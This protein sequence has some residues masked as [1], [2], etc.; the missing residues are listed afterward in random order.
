MHKQTYLFNIQHLLSQRYLDYSQLEVAVGHR[1]PTKSQRN[2]LKHLQPP[3]HNY[4]AQALFGYSLYILHHSTLF[5]G[6]SPMAIS[7]STPPKAVH[8]SNFPHFQP[9][10]FVFSLQMFVA[11]ASTALKSFSF[12]FLANKNGRFLKFFEYC[13][14]WMTYD[15]W[16]TY[17]RT[18]SFHTHKIVCAYS[19]DELNIT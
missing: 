4:M 18:K 11:W 14:W 9:V 3:T 5:C 2:I 19:I 16:Y 1:K 8:S 13:L 10:V 12:S 15:I 7:F 6:C 17:I